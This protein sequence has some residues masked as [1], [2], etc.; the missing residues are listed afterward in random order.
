MESHSG[1]APEGLQVHPNALSVPHLTLSLPRC[2]SETDGVRGFTDLMGVPF[3]S[4]SN[5]SQIKFV[6]CPALKYVS[7]AGPSQEWITWLFLYF[8][9]FFTQEVGI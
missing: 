5:Y 9:H 6:L 8:W 3:W 7:I 4:T 2:A 1:S